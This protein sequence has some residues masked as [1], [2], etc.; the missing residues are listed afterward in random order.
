MLIA[1]RI[2][3]TLI[4]MTAY[5][6]RESGVVEGE[7]VSSELNPFSIISFRSP[8]PTRD[9]CGP[10]TVTLRGRSEFLGQTVHVVNRIYSVYS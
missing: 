10:S 3:S 9:E 7:E 1:L 5:L 8:N 6:S 4:G 2:T